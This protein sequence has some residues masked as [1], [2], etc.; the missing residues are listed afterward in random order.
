M[1]AFMKHLS[2]VLILL[3]A[4][5]FLCSADCVLFFFLQQSDY[6]GLTGCGVGF[7]PL[8]TERERQL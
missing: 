3:L 7:I 6:V 5:I 2:E 4:H 8:H 1:W